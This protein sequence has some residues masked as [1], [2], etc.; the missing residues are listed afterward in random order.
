MGAGSD[1][2]AARVTLRWDPSPDS[3]V[4]GYRVHAQ[5][6]GAAPKTSLDVS[7]TSVATIDNLVEGATYSIYITAY[8]SSRVESDPSNQVSYTVPGLPVSGFALQFG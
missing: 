5:Q 7:N 8:D 1:A 3:N 4:V 2:N 6:I